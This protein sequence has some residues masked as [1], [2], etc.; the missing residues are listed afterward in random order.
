[1]TKPEYK[2]GSWKKRKVKV[3]GGSV[4]IHLKRVKPKLAKCG[5][6]GKPLHGIPRLRQIKFRKLSKTE[7]RPE[8]PYGGIL[9]SE[10]MRKIFQK[11][12]IQV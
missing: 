11:K 2:S 5:N 7:K 12:A 1:M 10:C 6:C 8:R 4:K 9:C 3:P